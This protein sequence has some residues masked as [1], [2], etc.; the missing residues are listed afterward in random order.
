MPH[1]SDNLI[2]PCY[3][4]LSRHL[5]FVLRFSLQALR[6][7]RHSLTLPPG[8][9]D[10]FVGTRL[11]LFSL[12]CHAA[13]TVPCLLS[14]AECLFLFLLGL[15]HAPPI[16]T[17]WP[18]PYCLLTTGLF[19]S[20]VN[21][22]LAHEHEIRPPTATTDRVCIATMECTDDEYLQVAPTPTSNAVCRGRRACQLGTRRDPPPEDVDT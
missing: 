12:L 19:T 15:L 14:I 8:F 3:S 16:P 5:L 18:C 21:S 13:P 7:V 17:Y 9:S 10:A 20:A 2:S 4:S 11:F 6:I 1:P 22:C